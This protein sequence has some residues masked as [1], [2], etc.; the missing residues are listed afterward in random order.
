M[1]SNTSFPMLAVVYNRWLAVGHCTG[2]PES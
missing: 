2:L 1:P